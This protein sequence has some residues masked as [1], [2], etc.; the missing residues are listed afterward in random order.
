MAEEPLSSV[1]IRILEQIQKDSSLSTSDLAD[2][3]GLSQSPCWRRLQRLKDEG[4]IKGQVAL[5]D[6]HKFGASLM[7]FAYLKMT[8]LTD[9]KRA[10]FLRKIEIT[11]EILEC[12]SL[13]GEKDIMLKVVAPSMEWYQ[14]FI[15]NVI[16]K[17][18]GVVDIQ[19]T[20]TLT[21]L[22]ST[23]AIPLRGSK[24]L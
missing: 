6:R 15:F 22:K 3:V 23:T 16:L 18:P 19:S 5:L 10:E 9:E 7:L 24:A 2:R 4:Y 1:D 21:E 8:T 20:V 12:H 17:L 11:P 14:K 13:F